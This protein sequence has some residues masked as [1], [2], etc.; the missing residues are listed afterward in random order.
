MVDLA[1]MNGKVYQDGDFV[2]ANVYVDKDI[3]QAVTA[4]TYPAATEVDAKGMLVFPGLIDPHVHFD[5]DLGVM[6]SVD[7]FERGSLLAALGGVTTI[8]DFLDPAD[9]P[10]DLEMKYRRRVFEAEDSKVDYM[11]HAC[12]KEPHCDLE[13]F[14]IKMMSLGMNTLKCFTTYSDS[15]RMIN[16]NEIIELL[17]LSEKYHFL[18]MVHVEDDDLI[19]LN[20][21]YTFRELGISRPKQAEIQKA[22]QLAGYVTRYGGFLYM[23]HVSSGETIENL[24][25]YYPEILNRRFFLESCPQYFLFDDSVFSQKDGYL[26][27]TAPPI[28]S[29]TEKM[30]LNANIDWIYAIGTDHCAFTKS[31]KH[32]ELLSEIPLGIGSIEHSFDVMY[33]LYGNKIV[34][35]M[36][37]HPAQMNGLA[38]RKGKI[39]AGYDADLFL[40]RPGKGKITED[41]SGSDYSVYMGVQK[42]GTVVSTLSNGSFIVRDR[43]F[44]NGFGRLLKGGRL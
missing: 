29:K 3:F 11:F 9:T 32:G 41:H 2:D 30:Y 1:I 26:Y 18:L 14:V 40:Y 5:L 19:D 12:I 38:G 36:T 34:E 6:R 23:V 27:T 4:E 8:I 37:T 31:Q 43:E 42:A 17:K 16:D 33:N 44:E 35:K 20:P 39:K 7:N 28:R 25:E 15:Q 24:K 10:A 21:S 22:L 13:S